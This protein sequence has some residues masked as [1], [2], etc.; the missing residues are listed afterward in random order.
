VFGSLTL[1]GYDTSKFIE[2]NVTWEMSE[3]FKDLTVQIEAIV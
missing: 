2:N 1:G 3:D